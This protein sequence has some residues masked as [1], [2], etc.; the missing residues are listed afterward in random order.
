MEV[1]ALLKEW[2]PWSLTAVAAVH[3]WLV[4]L[5]EIKDSR[6]ARRRKEASDVETDKSALKI[7]EDIKKA[8]EEILSMAKAAK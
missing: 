5:G 8:T 1:A 2:G 6:E 3:L 7:L 4:V